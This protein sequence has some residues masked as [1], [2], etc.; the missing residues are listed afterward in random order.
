MKSTKSI[1]KYRAFNKSSIELLINRELWFAKPSTLNDPFE[2][3]MIFP[4]FL[5]AIWRHHN[6][7]DTRKK[8]VEK[9]LAENL[10]RAGIC[11]FSRTRKN[12]LMWSHYSDEHKGFCL[13]FDEQHLRENS[14]RFHLEDVIYQSEL[15][16]KGVIER[17]KFFDKIPNGNNEYQIASDIL[18]SIMVTKYINWR[19]EKEVRLIRH[20][21]GALKFD[22]LSVRSI[23]LGLRMNQRDKITLKT[24]L[25]GSEWAHLQW[26]QAEKAK[27]KFGLEFVKI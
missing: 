16:Y 22:P 17:I 24:L 5:E 2:C 20:E 19:Y 10:E 26:Y 3:Q 12:Q 13:G 25:S 11:S 27:D 21:S 4:E 23:A 8:I 1:F 15:P 7:A 18:S 6:L 14:E 9:T